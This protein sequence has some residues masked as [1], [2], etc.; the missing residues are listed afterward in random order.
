MEEYNMAS[1]DSWI[2]ELALL[3]AET[4]FVDDMVNFNWKPYEE[5]PYV[6]IR[7]QKRPKGLKY[8]NV[9]PVKGVRLA[10]TFKGFRYPIGRKNL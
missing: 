8:N 5:P 4:I 3:S 10:R 1:P 6:P 9:K 7:H 2:S